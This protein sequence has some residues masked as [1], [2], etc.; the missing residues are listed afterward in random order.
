MSATMNMIGSHR[1]GAGA[2]RKFVYAGNAIVTVVSGKTGGRFTLRFSRAKVRGCTC[3]NVEGAEDCAAC[4]RDTA[5]PTWFVKV[6]TGSDNESD[7]CY[8]YVGFV[9]GA[10][11]SERHF[12]H[13]GAKAKA[14]P[15]APSVVAAGWVVSALATLERVLAAGPEAANAGDRLAGALGQ[16]GQAEMW[17]EGV[18]GR[19]AHRLTVPE[20]I[21]SGLGPVCAT[22]GQ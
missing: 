15:D 22:R 5:E 21:E 7:K 3:A 1:M 20:S 14:G 9:K 2:A 17:H 13:G 18:C 16:L 12:I 19:C 11:G 10:E 8:S 4:Q 6:L